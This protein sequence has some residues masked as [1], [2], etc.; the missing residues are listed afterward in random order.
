MVAR[1]SIG[2]GG[3][4]GGRGGPPV[5]R[6]C[7]SWGICIGDRLGDGEPGTAVCGKG[8]IVLDGDCDGGSNQLFS[9]V[10]AEWTGCEKLNC[11]VG[12]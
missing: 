4:R 2:T 8:C 10:A 7:N 3:G 9:R 1:P 12:S 5:G 11:E 6:V